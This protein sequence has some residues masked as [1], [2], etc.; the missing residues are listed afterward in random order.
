MPS[1]DTF[2][3]VAGSCCLWCGRELPKQEGRGRR[4]KYCNQGCKQ[5][6]YEQRLRFSG[7]VIPEDAVVLHTD[8]VASLH[9][10]LFELR[11]IAED[12]LTALEEGASSSELRNICEELVKAARAAEKLR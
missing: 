10:R 3:R 8:N 9:D 1:D 6:A 7:T 4:K 2:P 5:R 12:I 11:C